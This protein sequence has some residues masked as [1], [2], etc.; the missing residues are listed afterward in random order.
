MKQ[1]NF[2]VCFTLCDYFVDTLEFPAYTVAVVGAV[3]VATPKTVT[4]ASTIAMI[5]FA[6]PQFLLCI[7]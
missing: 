5:F 6:I 4:T 2:Y 1:E 3:N 7:I